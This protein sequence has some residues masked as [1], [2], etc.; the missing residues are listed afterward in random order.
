M[1]PK[2][3]QLIEYLSKEI[4]TQSNHLMTFRTRISFVVVAGPFI[5]TSS[6][7]FATRGDF[8]ITT[9]PF[10]KLGILVASVLVVISYMGMGYLCHQIDHGFQEQC[11][12]WRSLI[13]SLSEEDDVTSRRGQDFLSH[14]RS[15]LAYFWGFGLML[16]VFFSMMFLAGQMLGV[17]EQGESQSS[18]MTVR[19]PSASPCIRPAAIRL[20]LG[21]KTANLPNTKIA[22]YLSG[23]TR[24]FA[25]R[26]RWKR[27]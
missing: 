24:R 16:M 26:P 7:L 8:T 21:L 20:D 17:G 5:V 1:P 23:S 13:L 11:N 4:E 12:K 2:E 14:P 3:Q 19:R 25:S 27:S 15:R 6:V 10:S 9:D 22:H 18:P